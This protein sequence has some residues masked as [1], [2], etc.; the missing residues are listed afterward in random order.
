[1]DALKGKKIGFIGGGKM[2]EAMIRGL[3]SKGVQPRQVLAYDTDP[4]RR[5][6]LERTYKIQTAKD[7]TEVA[8]NAAVVVFA[9]KP[10]VM[11]DVLA[12]LKPVEKKNSGPLF[13]SIAAGVPLK[14]ISSQL[15]KAA[16]IV[17]V[18]PNTPALIRQGISAYY[19]SPGCKPADRKVVEAILLALGQ[20]VEVKDE[21]LM[22]PVTGLSG[23]GPA[24]IYVIIDALAD[25]GVKLGL[26]REVAL[27]LA[28][29]TAAGAARM[30]VETGRHP[31]ELKDMVT[32]PGGTTAAGL[33]ELEKGGLRGILIR[34]V[35]AAARKSEELGGKNSSSK[36]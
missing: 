34:A 32:S 9:V 27:R 36:K 11:K 24:Y 1:M 5:S 29:N 15:G 16:R 35:E 7:N 30:V 19:A 33:Y 21:K 23:S 31:A 13:I 3:V 12:K 25:A 8:A 17:R 26:S 20:V 4:K 10:Q 2:A 14:E 6:M 28:A 22:D 18:M